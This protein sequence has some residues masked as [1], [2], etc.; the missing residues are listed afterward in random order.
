M[1]VS[2]VL[3]IL[4][5]GLVWRWWSGR[6]HNV[7][8]KIAVGLIFGL[9]SVL[10]THF[11]TD[12]NDMILNVR[13]LGPLAA[14]LF[15]DPVS[16]IIAGLIGGAERYFAGT[17]LG[18]GAFT[19]T[20]CSLSTC[21]AGFFSAILRGVLFENR[22]PPTTIFFFIGAVMEVFHMYAVLITNRHSM[23]MAFYVVKNCAVPMILSSGI[24]L[25]FC[26]FLIKQL[27][28]ENNGR[29]PFSDREHTPVTKQFHRWLLIVT[30]FIVFVNT[31]TDYEL[32]TRAAFQE[33][34]QS[35]ML[36]ADDCK[37]LFI[38][39]ADDP[40]R[41]AE[42]MPY[43]AMAMSYNATYLVFD[44]D[45]NV[46]AGLYS[47]EAGM[48]TVSES[49]YTL[50]SSQAEKPPFKAAPEY[51][52]GTDTLCIVKHLDNDIY[53]MVGW[54]YDA[55]YSIRQNQM[56]ENILSDILLFTALFIL[57]SLLLERI[58]VRN[59][60]SVNASLQKIIGGDLGERVTA[61]SSAEFSLLSDDINQTVTTLKGYID[62][63][64]KR[65]E[66]ELR[67]ASFIQESALPHVFKYPRDDIEIYALMKP[68][69][70]VGGDFYD[71]FFTDVD[72][73]VLVIAD[74]SG[75]G[76]P[77]AM[78]MMRAKTAIVNSARAGKSPADILYEVN[79]VLCEGNE[80]EMFVTVWIG[81]IDLGTGLM[82]CAN[83]GHEYPAVCRSGSGY[84]LLR[85]KHSLVLAAM[86]DVP[87]SEY[88]LHMKPGDRIFVYT[89]GVPEAINRQNEQYGTDRLVA[90]LHTLSTTT[91]KLTL[92]TVYD[93]IKAFAGSA[94]QFDDITMLGFTYCGK[95]QQ[96]PEDS[97]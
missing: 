75:K 21:L 37:R 28:G 66:E 94:E 27:S 57:I 54:R 3:F 59:L 73:L 13:D 55:I 72:R 35:L 79:N 8:H 60:K 80:A 52:G 56:Y 82:K 6:E 42:L 34:S 71:F 53:L 45:R 64:E 39:M 51:Y 77:A 16:G 89:D 68:A 58:V 47:R 2:T 9:F 76:I 5:A 49:D 69:R 36:L 15:F 46:I 11:G 31:I 29:V 74:V 20:A 50:L 70:Q 90:R 97:Q 40:E 4:L 63:S 26:S 25:A 12:Y 17:F 32:R 23:V 78:F 43:V 95:E 61:R 67:L 19:T 48:P 30:I 38:D 14:G 93:D 10:A 41:A 18:L 83:A 24:G 22:R 81:I 87:M 62:E 88:T 44:S 65:M 7:W 33:T 1:T 92:E 84:E 91:E 85:D 86:E 96:S